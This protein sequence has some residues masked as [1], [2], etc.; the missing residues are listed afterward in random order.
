MSVLGSKIKAHIRNGQH[1][2]KIKITSDDGYIGIY[3]TTLNVCN[4]MDI[5]KNTRASTFL[6]PIEIAVQ[7]DSYRGIS[8]TANVTIIPSR[9]GNGKISKPFIFVEGF[10]PQTSN[11]AQSDQRSLLFYYR[12]WSK[13]K[14][15]LIH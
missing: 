6:Q 9:L 11:N 4:T 10:N 15:T 13:F 7:G 3:T 1:N 12:A 2:I 5:K 8:T 14:R